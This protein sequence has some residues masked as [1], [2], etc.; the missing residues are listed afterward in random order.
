MEERGQCDVLVKKVEVLSKDM[1]VERISLVECLSGIKQVER[2]L[3]SYNKG[4]A[5]EEGTDQ[6]DR[7]RQEDGAEVFPHSGSTSNN[8]KIHPGPT[9][10][11]KLD[12]HLTRP[13][14]C[15]E[16]SSDIL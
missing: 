5:Q 13:H 10:R 6:A 8:P 1:K 14:R 4:G 2:Y 16:M 9:L 15:N 11:K 12:Q 7:C 3:E